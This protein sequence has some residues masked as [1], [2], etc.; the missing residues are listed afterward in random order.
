MKI[1]INLHCSNIVI[2]NVH[3]IIIN[4]RGTCVT[5]LQ[6]VAESKECLPHPLDNAKTSSKSFLFIMIIYESLNDWDDFNPCWR[7]TTKERVDT[8]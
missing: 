3:M 6:I 2:I 4:K 7:A 8:Q 1:R 5:L